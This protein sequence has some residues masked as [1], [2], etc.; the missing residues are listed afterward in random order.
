[1]NK[2]EH[3]LTCLIEE[4]LEVGK[5]ATKAQRFGLT[6]CSPSDLSQETNTSRLV[7]EM[8]EVIAVFEWLQD[9]HVLP[10]GDKYGDINRKQAKLEAMIEIAIQRGNLE[11]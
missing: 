10:L 5:E 1:M 2:I 6:G 8:H 7:R 3:L 11:P 9:L 4:C